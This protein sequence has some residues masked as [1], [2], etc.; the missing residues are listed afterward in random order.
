MCEIPAS[1]IRSAQISADA[2]GEAFI[3]KARES[4]SANLAKSD[5]WFVRIHPFGIDRPTVLAAQVDWDGTVR[6][7]YGFTAQ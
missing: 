2:F 3:Y 4:A 5:D 7:Q 6:L 1:I